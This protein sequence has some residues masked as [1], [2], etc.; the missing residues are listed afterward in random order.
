MK[1]ENCG[2][3]METRQR[4]CS[5]CGQPLEQEQSTDNEQPNLNVEHSDQTHTPEEVPLTD[6]QS[7]EDEEND[8]S[9][10]STHP[11][12]DQEVEKENE[13]SEMADGTPLQEPAAVS[14]K[15]IKIAKWTTIVL[16]TVAVLTAAFVA[17]ISF[18][19]SE[20]NPREVQQVAAM[21][22]QQELQLEAIYMNQDELVIYPKRMQ[23]ID[24]YVYPEEADT[25][26]LVWESSNTAIQV[27]QSG[28]VTSNSEN[29]SGE[30]T[31]KNADGTIKT[32]TKV[33]V[34]S[35][36]D[37]FYSTL[38]FINNNTEQNSVYLDYEKESF[39]VNAKH[40]SSIVESG[41]AAV[42]K[43]VE[44]NIEQ[45]NVYQ[46]QF[47]NKQTDNSVLVDVYSHPTTNE[48]NKIVAIEYMEN[49]QLKITDFYYQNGA[50]AFY[51]DRFE[52]YY[53]P[54]AARQDFEGVRAFIHE[55]AVI[56]YREI[57]HAGDHFQKTDYTFDNEKIDWKVYEYQ[58]IDRDDVNKEKASYEKPGDDEEATKQRQQQF[59]Q[60]EQAIINASHNIY[61]A[62]VE[63][64]DIMKVSGYVAFPNNSSAQGVKVKIFSEKFKLLVGEGVTDVDGYYEFNVPMGQGDYRV[65]VDHDSYRK[66]SIYAIDSNQGISNAMQETI[67]LFSPN[68]TGYTVY[69][70]LIDALSGSS[71]LDSVYDSS[72][73]EET[74]DEYGM[75]IV[76]E[77]EPIIAQIFV[78][79]GI[80]N[81]SG[82]VLQSYQVDL[83]QTQDIELMLDGGNYTIEIVLNGYE[84]NYITVS[85]LESG[86]TVQSNIVPKIEG[87]EMRIVLNWSH[88][89]S[90]LDSHLFFPDNGHIAYYEREHKGNFLD[91]DDTSGYGPETITVNNIGAG[92]Y[93]YYV[94]DFSNLS[95]DDYTSYELSNSFARVDVYSK[96]GLQSF[97]VPRNQPAVIWQVFNISNGQI[98]PIQRLYYNVEDY[99]WW[100]SSKW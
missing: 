14:P 99:D 96:H 83:R 87:N 43:N 61:R 73:Y 1:C 23:R 29:V 69:L 40:D 51:F 55:D 6:D 11:L 77:Y 84:R 89:P 27:N 24:Y 71:I 16:S 63:Q 19:K 2:H 49:E 70:N 46:K 26:S 52:N 50:P 10:Q 88:T 86:M 75:L 79:G 65:L 17:F 95:D 90:D 37:A 54:V 45:Y 59:I 76:P 60:D 74:Y 38:D 44:E 25:S 64:P 58:D 100:T 93:K 94:A 41:P 21:E 98:I 81:K 34:G 78:R 7:V 56:R 97:H 62:V 47:I 13:E 8:E 92:T 72:D 48:I 28:Y 15:A 22:E 35:Q 9:D 67:Y 4:F 42:F 32:T 57:V 36:D 82:T 31:L 80:N 12:I 33:V 18:W 53:R 91:V 66:T 5:N 30:I 85:T 3:E 68:D 39:K 20:N